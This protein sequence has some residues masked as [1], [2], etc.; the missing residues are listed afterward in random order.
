MVETFFLAQII[1]VYLVV[2]GFSA[3]MH[4]ARV[5]S[6]MAEYLKSSIIP[7]FDAAIALL[8]GLLIVLT[9]NV[10][11]DLPSSLVSLVGWI[12]VIEGVALFLLPEETLKIVGKWMRAPSVMKGMVLVCIVAGLYLVYYGFFM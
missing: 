2:A 3:L 8:V 7:Y 12:A 1:G 10:W 11:V 6:A 5:K 4:P 9:H